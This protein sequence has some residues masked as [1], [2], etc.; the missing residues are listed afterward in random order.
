MDTSDGNAAFPAWAFRTCTMTSAASSIARLP[1]PVPIGGA[2]R[3]ANDHGVNH[4]FSGK[5]PPGGGHDRSADR[6]LLLDPEMAGELRPTH[7]LESPYH[8]R[9]GIESGRRGADDR[10]GSEEREIVHDH[11]DHLPA[12]SRE[13]RYIRVASSGW[14]SRSSTMPRPY[15]AFGLRGSSSTARS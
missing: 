8:R 6:Q 3:L 10:V 13:R 7:L 9:R 15:S 11:T 4:E 14:L 1:A 5:V 12:A 2:V